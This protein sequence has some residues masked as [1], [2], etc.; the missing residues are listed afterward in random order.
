M[1]A[2][3]E[4]KAREELQPIVDEIASDLNVNT[5]DRMADYIRLQGDPMLSPEQK[6]SLAISGWLLGSGS[7]VDN[8]GVSKSL[9]EVRDMVQRYLASTR[10]PERDGILLQ[11]ESHPGASPAY[12]AKILAHMKP[13]LEKTAEVEV[14]DPGD[15]AKVLGLEAG[16]AAG[17][18]SAEPV[19]KPVERPVPAPVPARAVPKAAVEPKEAGGGGGQDAGP[20]NILDDPPAARKPAGKA[21]PKPAAELPAGPEAAAEAAS[22][23]PV[24]PTGIP[25]MFEIT[26]AGLPEE[27]QIKY[28]LQLPP[29]YDPYRRY[30]C[31]VTLNGAG[32]TPQQQIDWW[33]G[34]YNSDVNTRFGQASRHG[35][36]VLAPRWTREHQRS[37]EFSAREHAA[38]LYTLRDAC[39]RFSI[40][41]DRVFLSGHSMGGDAAWDIGL[42]HPDLWAGVIPIVAIADKYVKHKYQENAKYVPLYFVCGEKDG[43]KLALNSSEWDHYFRHIGYDTMV[44]QYQGRGHEH[45]HDEIQR[46]FDWMNLHKRDFFPKDF[47]VYSMRP[48]DNF[49]WWVETD[50]PKPANI[51]LPMEWPGNARA[52]ETEGRVLETNAVSVTSG[53]DRVTVWLSPE[54]VNF[55]GKVTVHIKGKRFLNIQPS[56]A[57]MLEDARTR[58]DRQHPF[59]AKVS[60]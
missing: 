31:V 9:V 42:A 38:A 16:A 6:L 54:I 4:D 47:T 37:Y 28:Y 27:P 32:T 33:A 23:G 22:T 2:L 19:A 26:V 13:P 58:V 53:A 41:T 51:V 5:L 40:D 60:N 24:Q 7:G 36:I 56:V 10:K 55:E 21:P 29:E 1:E 49:F 43:N 3:K 14:V 44:V 8:L 50:K 59:W 45:F 20:L 15:A 12:V 35:Y 18:K 39:K 30:P 34:G 11:L 46:I 48:W 52:Y 25:G 57:A 17:E